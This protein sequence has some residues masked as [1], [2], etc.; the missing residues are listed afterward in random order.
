MKAED[1]IGSIVTIPPPKQWPS[2]Y[3]PKSHEV[4]NEKKHWDYLWHKFI[5]VTD[6]IYASK[7]W[8]PS[9]T[10]LLSNCQIRNLM[11]RMERT[12]IQCDHNEDNEHNVF[13]M[14][15]NKT[16]TI[17]LSKDLVL[18]LQGLQYLANM[19]MV[20]PW[21]S[22]PQSSSAMLTTVADHTGYYLQKN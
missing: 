15:C 22:E 20:E 17:I 11:P 7:L 14:C 2:R 8:L 6:Q 12:S 5:S 19:K 9:S 13:K 4:H 1:W 16:R 21:L 18:Y 3:M 10:K